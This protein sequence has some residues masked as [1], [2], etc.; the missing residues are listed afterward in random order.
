MPAQRK[1]KISRLIQRDLGEFFQREGGRMFDGVMITVTKVYVTGD[2]SLARIFL[3]LFPSSKKSELIQT[4]NDKKKEIRYHL[5][6]KVRHQLRS[7]PDLEFFLDDSLDYID[8]IENLLK[9]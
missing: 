4:I 1:D 5:A 3:S 9:E 2:L 8:N 6:A 7:V